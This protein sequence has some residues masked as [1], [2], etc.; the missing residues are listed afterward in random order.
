[1]SWGWRDEAAPPAPGAVVGIGAVARALLAKLRAVEEAARTGLSAT[2]H[3]SLLLI[4]GAADRLPWMDGVGYAAAR[5]DAPTLWL[6]TARTPDVPLDLLAKAIAR[7]HGGHPM[8]LWPDPAQLVPL[9][10][11]LPATDAVLDRIAV[12]WER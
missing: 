11:L 6:P 2:A 5:A 4:T 8:L 3:P 9:H 12:L 7:R 10:R 1:M